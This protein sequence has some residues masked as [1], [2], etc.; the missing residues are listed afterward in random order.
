MPLV[1]FEAP[2]FRLWRSL[3]TPGRLVVLGVLGAVVF[4]VAGVLS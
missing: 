1:R 3:T 4:L 2:P